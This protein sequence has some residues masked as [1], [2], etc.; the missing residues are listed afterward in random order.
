[1]VDAEPVQAGTARPSPGVEAFSVSIKRMRYIAEPCN[2][3]HPLVG[4]AGREPRLSVAFTGP[5]R[6]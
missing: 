2:P 3:F 6:E 4:N 5:S 1:M